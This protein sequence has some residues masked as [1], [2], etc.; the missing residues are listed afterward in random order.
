MDL[1]LL[2][3]IKVITDD[4]SKNWAYTRKRLREMERTGNKVI[5]TENLTIFP[6]G[7]RDDSASLLAE[8]D[9]IALI[10]KGKLSHVVEILDKSPYEG[11]GWFHRFVKVWWWQPGLEWENLPPQSDMLGFDP[12]LMDGKPHRIEGLKR[13]N[14]KWTN[15]GGFEAFKEYLG[16]AVVNF[17]K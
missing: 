13:Y 3:W 4:D 9:Y 12:Y 11:G 8:G 2:Q 10:Q 1:S 5:D 15:A 14:E 16:K 17:T 6:L 7:F